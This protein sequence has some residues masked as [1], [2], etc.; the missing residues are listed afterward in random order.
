MEL[1]KGMVLASVLSM[2]AGAVQAQDIGFGGNVAVLSEYISSGVTMSSGRPAL[3]FTGYAYIPQGLYAGV[4]LST[5]NFTTF[6]PT[7]RDRVELGLF[8]GWERA[9]AN[10]LTL[11]V[12][13]EHYFYDRSGECCGQFYLGAS[14]F[15]GDQLELAA[16]LQYDPDADTLDT[17]GTVTVYPT[18][19]I[20]L[21]AMI[22]RSQ[23]YSHTYM[24]LGVDYFFTDAVTGSLDLHRATSPWTENRV[25]AGLRYTF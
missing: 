14:T 12:G 24:N 7:D 3:Q 18:D 23:A 19:S 17:R 6:D 20:G 15:V 16:L 5:V 8:V 11:D 1:R 13:Y 22:G 9:F 25:V 4:F 21:R 10:G 2:S